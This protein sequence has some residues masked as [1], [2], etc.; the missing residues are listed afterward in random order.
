M[1]ARCVPITIPAATSGGLSTNVGGFVFLVILGVML[2]EHDLA[3][4]V[5]RKRLQHH[6]ETVAVIVR[7]GD[8]NVGFGSCKI[9]GE[10][11]YFKIDYYS[12][13]MQSGSED[14]CNPKKTTRVLTIIY[15]S[16]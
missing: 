12:T 6:I 16:D 9:D 15:A 7:E 4:V 8:A 5:E 13:D 10:T 11:F 3:V 14:P 2:A 1:L